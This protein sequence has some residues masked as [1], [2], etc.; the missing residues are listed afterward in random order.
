M[1][2]EQDNNEARVR[3]KEILND[4]KL[5]PVQAEF[6]RIPIYGIKIMNEIN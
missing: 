6:S 4:P 3:I 2:N 5:E 1:T